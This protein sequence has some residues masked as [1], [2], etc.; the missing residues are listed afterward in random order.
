M[1]KHSYTTRSK[2][3]DGGRLRAREPSPR[4][5][6]SEYPFCFHP[7]R[8]Q[9]V[10]CLFVFYLKSTMLTGRRQRNVERQD[11]PFAGRSGNGAVVVRVAVVRV[12][13]HLYAVRLPFDVR[14][15]VLLPPAGRRLQ[16]AADYLVHCPVFFPTTVTLVGCNEQNESALFIFHQILVTTLMK[17][18]RYFGQPQPCTD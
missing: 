7:R 8:V 10:F 17:T 4:L 16:V 5:H 13:K 15:T 6:H 12:D 14:Q 11:Q 9:C 3:R 18:G 2:G 1:F